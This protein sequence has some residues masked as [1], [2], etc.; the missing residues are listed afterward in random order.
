ML[1]KVALVT[2]GAQGIGLAISAALLKSGAKVC[3]E[4]FLQMTCLIMH[5]IPYPGA[6]CTLCNFQVSLLDVRDD[7]G[8]AACKQLQ[9]EH[10]QDRVIFIRCDV[11]NKDQLVCA[12]DLYAGE[13]F[14]A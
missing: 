12:I 3:W 6:G 5:R 9:M 4:V 8:L 2:G 11:T 7:L 10:T 14:E 1:N 13:V